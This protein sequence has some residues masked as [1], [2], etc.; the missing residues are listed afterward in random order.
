M[1]KKIFY[2]CT[3][4]FLPDIR[5]PAKSLAAGHPAKSVSGTT[6]F[7][8]YPSIYNLYIH[9]YVYLSIYF[10]NLDY[11]EEDGE[12]QGQGQGED[13][14]EDPEGHGEV[15]QTAQP[16]EEQSLPRG[17]YTFPKGRRLKS[18]LKSTTTC[19][20]KLYGIW[21]AEN[22]R[23]GHLIWESIYLALI[24]RYLSADVGQLS[25]LSL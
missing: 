10:I 19:R 22:L 21:L 5:Y 1:N 15:G 7:P 2:F 20:E 9:P 14:Q 3:Y 25:L 23:I 17:G 8:I 16:E 6:L 12:E 24:D 13:G 11:W 18:K 4:Y